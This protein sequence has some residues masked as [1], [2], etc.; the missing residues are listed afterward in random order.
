VFGADR[1][2]GEGG[3]CGSLALLAAD[4]HPKRASFR[5]K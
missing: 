4:C 3:E 2:S 5:C 1:A